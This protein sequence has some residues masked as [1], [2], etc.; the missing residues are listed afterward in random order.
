MPRL[1]LPVDVTLQEDLEQIVASNIPWQKLKNSTVLITGATGLIGRQ[2]IF[3]LSTANRVYDCNIRILALVRSIEKAERIFC[4]LLCQQMLEIIVCDITKPIFIKHEVDYIYHMASVTSSKELVSHPVEAIDAAVTGTK[5]I[6]N[7]AREK[8]CRSVVYLSSMEVY[9]TVTAVDD[10]R[11][12]ECELGYIDITKVRSCYPEAKR[13]CE[14]MCVCYCYQYGVP[15]KIARLAQTFGAGVDISDNRVFAQFAR[16]AMEGKDII[17]H[18]KGASSGNYCYTADAIVGLL[19]ILLK[20]ISSEAYNV[21]SE[22]TTTTIA[23]MAEMVSEKISLGKSNVVFDIPENVLTYGYAADVKLRLSG[24]KLESLG[25]KPTIAPELETM[26][27]RLVKS[28]AEQ[29]VEALK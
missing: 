23:Q 19:T 13:L 25:W 10:H 20:G 18:T 26:Y 7:L 21:V 27:A 1:E 29:N 6:L 24:A 12:S 3:A 15:V 9:G 14:N 5:N 16:A 2:M 8:K 4:E 28:F 17:L 11:T 22:R